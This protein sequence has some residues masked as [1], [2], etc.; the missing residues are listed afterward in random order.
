LGLLAVVCGDGTCVVLAL[1][2]ALAPAPGSGGSG[3]SGSGGGGVIPEDAVR[4]WVIRPHAGAPGSGTG[5]TGGAAVTPGQPAPSSTL[6]TSASWSAHDP[7]ELCCG[8][9]DGSVALWR[10]HPLSADTAAAAADNGGRAAVGRRGKQGVRELL[11]PAPHRRLVDLSLPF[12][13]TPAAAVRAASVCPYSP[14]LVIAG[15]YST[16]VPHTHTRMDALLVRSWGHRSAQYSC[17]SSHPDA[18]TPPHT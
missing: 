12:H 13:I 15:G 1:P 18:P 2:T 11:T 9:G 16:Q 7:L 10:L 6:I 14:D 17:P 4:K 8:L 5:G 3:G